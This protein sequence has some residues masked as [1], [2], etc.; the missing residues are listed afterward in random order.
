MMK[1]K[2]IGCLCT[3]N[4]FMLHNVAILLCKININN[5]ENLL[6]THAFDYIVLRVNLGLTSCEDLATSVDNSLDNN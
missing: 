6:A 2:I 4:Y 3:Q 1:K 5:K